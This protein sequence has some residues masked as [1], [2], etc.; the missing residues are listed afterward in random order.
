M[1][2]AIDGA[3]VLARSVHDGCKARTDPVSIRLHDICIDP[4]LEALKV[5]VV[6]LTNIKKNYFLA[7]LRMAAVAKDV[8]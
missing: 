4:A 3:C 8:A 6:P 5:T 2:P 1:Q 7:N